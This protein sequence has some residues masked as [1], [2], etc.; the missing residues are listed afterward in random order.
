MI[1]PNN[2]QYLGLKSELMQRGI[3]NGADSVQI[4]NKH[5]AQRTINQSHGYPTA[6][7]V[8]GPG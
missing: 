5:E 7:P 2:T 1:S 8:L 3:G 4:K 6:H